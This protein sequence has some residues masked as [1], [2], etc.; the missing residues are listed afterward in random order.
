MLS[1]LYTPKEKTIQKMKEKRKENKV[2]YFKYLSACAMFV[3][4]IG[5][6]GLYYQKEN[7][8]IA[9]YP[10]APVPPFPYGPAII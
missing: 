7:T 5:L 2:V 4:A 8:K 10:V 1:T 3:V 6:G 9:K